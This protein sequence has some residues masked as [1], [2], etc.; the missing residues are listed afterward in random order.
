MNINA[1]SSG[2]ASGMPSAADLTTLP[3][4]NAKLAQ[5]CDQFEGIFVRQILSEG[6]KPLLAQ[7]PG[8]GGAG[9]DVYSYLTTDAMAKDISGKSPFG[10]S[11]LLQAQLAP[12]TP[13]SHPSPDAK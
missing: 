10:I 4:K 1:I 12:K 11:H 7:T 8:S 9:S 3:E 6:M 5:A 13:H 2:S